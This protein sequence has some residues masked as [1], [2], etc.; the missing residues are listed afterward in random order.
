[1][2]NIDNKDQEEL[3]KILESNNSSDSLEDEIY[4]YIKHVTKHMS[5]SIC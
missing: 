5:N 2:L 1:M 3:F 4:I